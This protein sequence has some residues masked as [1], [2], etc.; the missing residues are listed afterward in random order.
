MV[1]CSL[2]VVDFILNII[3]VLLVDSSF[4][5]IIYTVIIWVRGLA[6]KVILL[7]VDAR[8][9]FTLHSNSPPPPY[10]PQMQ[11]IMITGFVAAFKRRP[12][13][14]ALW[15]GMEVRRLLFC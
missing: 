13:L 4:S 14:L 3:Y 8:S 12:F 2:T 15:L 10:P 11:S 9:S 1:A 6:S 5:V 7:V